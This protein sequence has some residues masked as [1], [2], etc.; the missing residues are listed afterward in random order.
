M[1]FKIPIEE[2][3]LQIKQEKSDFE[4][5][6]SND[7]YLKFDFEVGVKVEN[8]SPAFEDWCLQNPQYQESIIYEDVKEECELYTCYICFRMFA[9]SYALYQHN[10]TH[11]SVVL[12]KPG[13]LYQCDHCS[14][15]FTKK[16]K[17]A[18]HIHSTHFLLF[19]TLPVIHNRQLCVICNKRYKYKIWHSHMIE[20]HSTAR[21]PCKLCDHTY[22]NPRNLHRHMLYVHQNVKCGWRCKKIEEVKCELCSSVLRS[23]SAY[24]THLRNCHSNEVQCELCHSTLKSRSYLLGHM[25]R[26]HYND[27]KMYPCS[28]CHKAFRSPRYLKVHMK[29]SH[30][31][32]VKTAKTDI[33][34]TKN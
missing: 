3:E 22:K 13:C 19:K 27:G 8:D 34:S 5:E 17:L 25:K 30:Y 10:I 12:T 11:L 31:V 6:D 33:S 21:I 29:N 28:I 24:K 15:Y 9:D 4:K 14:L 20:V 23:K 32:R 16:K 26:V 7:N 2:S 1:D 18:I